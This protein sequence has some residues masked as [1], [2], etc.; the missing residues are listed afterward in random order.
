VVR[1]G[2]VRYIEDDDVTRLLNSVE[3][4]AASV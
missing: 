1:A 2:V 3:R 4:V